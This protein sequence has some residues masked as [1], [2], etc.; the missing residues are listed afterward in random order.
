MTSGIYELTFSNGG[1]YIGKSIDVEARWKQHLDKLAKGNG[2]KPLQEAFDLSAGRFNARV[3][4]ECH[5]DH[6]DIMEECLIARMQPTLNTT[7][8][9]DRLAG[10]HD[11]DWIHIV[12]HF[13]MSTVEHIQ[14]LTHAKTQAR[15]ARA[16]LKN[17]E[18]QIIELLD[19]RSKEEL[20][21]DISGK[22]KELTEEVDELNQQLDE[23][24]EDYSA[25]IQANTDLRKRLAYAELP[26]WQKLF[27]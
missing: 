2:A 10:I 19:K 6:L 24:E 25:A 8:P 14:E 3:L 5:P 12:S 18:V 20:E 17:C 16:A 26:W 13:K 7:R 27:S 4:H 9:K 15:N 1:T 21:A 22:I 11:G 23:L